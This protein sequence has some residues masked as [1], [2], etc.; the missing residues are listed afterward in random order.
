MP[1]TK[2]YDHLSIFLFEIRQ[3]IDEA[4]DP[5]TP[6]QKLELANQCV[7]LSYAIAQ[8]QPVPIDDEEDQPDAHMD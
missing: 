7:E 6:A 8:K 4:K 3:L 5:P 1:A 2:R